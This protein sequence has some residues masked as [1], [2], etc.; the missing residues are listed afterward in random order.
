MTQTLKWKGQSTSQL[1]V[2]FDH[3]ADVQAAERIAHQAKVIATYQLLE[4]L[5][6]LAGEPVHSYTT[7]WNCPEG[8]LGTCAYGK[9]DWDQDHCLFCGDP[10]ERK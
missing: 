8:P 6:K 2:I 7:A 10:K 4:Q 3:L 5:S 1:G 9:D